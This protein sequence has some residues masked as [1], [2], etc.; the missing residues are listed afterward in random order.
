MELKD[1]KGNVYGGSIEIMKFRFKV[2]I[3]TVNQHN[4]EPH[5]ESKKH[6]VS[7]SF[8]INVSKTFNF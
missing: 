5:C 1:H 8:L 2:G 7:D 3:K 4:T 6:I